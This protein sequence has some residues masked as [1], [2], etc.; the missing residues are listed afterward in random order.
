MEGFIARRDI[1]SFTDVR[2]LSERSDAKGLAQ[3]FSHL[4]AILV[5]G[6]LIWWVMPYWWLLVPA[7]IIHGI[8]LAFLFCP[9]HE[10][11][12]RT[13]FKSRW[14]NETVAYVFGFAI[15]LPPAYFRFFHFEHHRETQIEGKDPELG[16]PKP[17]T[18]GALLWYLTGIKSYWW[19]M[20]K[21]VVSHALGR[22]T[23]PYIPDD[24]KQSV[25]HESRLFL[26]GYAVIALVAISAGSWAPI[27][28]WV[29]PLVLGMPFLRF[30]LLAEHTLLPFTADM[31]ANTRT[32]KTNG[33]IRWLSWQMPHHT[34]HHTFPSVPFHAL[35]AAYHKIAPRHEALI[36]GYAAFA[37]EY[38]RSLKSS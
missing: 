14:L 5:T 32:M 22:V 35:A 6:T 25:I 24:G 9:L 18:R 4:L 13:A 36:P 23:E 7:M 27:L 21:V 11:I 34:E 31:L 20:A 33:V 12:H 37:R 3:L 26:A 30:Y 17:R 1:C 29:L 28:Y 15:M 8:L 10:V 16:E 19:V 38:W 2:R